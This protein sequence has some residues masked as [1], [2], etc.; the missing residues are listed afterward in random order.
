VARFV[1]N[2]RLGLVKANWDENHAKKAEDITVTKADY[3]G[4]RKLDLQSL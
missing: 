4:I 3:L 2:A 1:Y